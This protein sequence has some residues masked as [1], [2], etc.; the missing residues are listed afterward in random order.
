MAPSAVAVAVA[1]AAAAWQAYAAVPPAA[2]GIAAP[3]GVSAAHAAA[4]LLPVAGQEARA[5]V[6]ALHSAGA[7]SRWPAAWLSAR[8]SVLWSLR[9]DCCRGTDSTGHH[10]ASYRLFP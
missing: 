10:R 2:A 9:M 3:P 6:A 5:V 8:R 7:A 1:V 4:A